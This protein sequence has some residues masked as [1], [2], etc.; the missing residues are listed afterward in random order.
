MNLITNGHAG[1]M[2]NVIR[3]Y[4]PD[5]SS[6]AIQVTG[7]FSGA[8]VKIEQSLDA[9]TWF[10]VEGADNITE[11]FFGYFPAIN[12]WVRCVIEGG[13]PY[14]SVKDPIIW[15]PNTYYA[16]GMIVY[17]VNNRRH[18]LCKE[19]HLD[20]TIPLIEYWENYEYTAEEV[21]NSN[22]TSVNVAVS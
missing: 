1:E 14:K 4:R 5:K 16:K 7:N 11:D 19:G 3:V 9:R 2:S 15:R 8:I 12:G 17:D 10:P 22:A 18:L 21:D 13:V 6:N 20:P